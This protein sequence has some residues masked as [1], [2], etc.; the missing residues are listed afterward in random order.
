MEQETGGNRRGGISARILSQTRQFIATV[1]GED[2]VQIAG[3][4]KWSRRHHFIIFLLRRSQI[5]EPE[6][7]TGF[8][9]T[10]GTIEGFNPSAV[11]ASSDPQ[12]SRCKDLEVHASR[13]IALQSNWNWN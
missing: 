5:R 2:G 10:I 9:L 1:F 7:H 4:R 8:T 11:E 3:L 13:L 12:S 6:S